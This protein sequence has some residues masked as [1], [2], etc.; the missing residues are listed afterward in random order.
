MNPCDVEG[1]CS[2]RGTCSYNATVVN[3]ASGVYADYEFTCTCDDAGDSVQYT[4]D[5]CEIA[6]YTNPTTN[7]TFTCQNGG[8]VT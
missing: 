4:G 7:D 1:V 2:D 6:V 3:L 5:D 8:T